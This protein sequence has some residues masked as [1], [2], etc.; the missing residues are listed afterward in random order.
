MITPGSSTYAFLVAG[1]LD[2]HWAAWL[3][4][5]MIIR[6]LDGSTTLTGT[7]TD[8]AHLHGI[9][10]HLRDSGATLLSVNLVDHDPA[11]PRRG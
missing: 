7:V 6:N 9:L 8:Q 1:H 11:G 2:D 3:D 5:F 10:A 4:D